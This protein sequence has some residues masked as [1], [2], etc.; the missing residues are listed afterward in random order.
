MKF[1]VFV[2]T[3]AFIAALACTSICF[4]RADMDRAMYFLLLA[5][6]FHIQIRD[7]LNSNN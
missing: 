6:L 7:I 4:V 1:F 2:L 3:L 5:I